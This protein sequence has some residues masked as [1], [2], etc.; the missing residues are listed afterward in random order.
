M[1]ESPRKFDD[2]TPE[3]GSAPGV[4]RFRVAVTFILWCV[5]T[6]V[7]GWVLVLIVFFLRSL[8]LI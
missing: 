4:D 5:L 2:V 6:L 3:R 8:S 7:G 1:P